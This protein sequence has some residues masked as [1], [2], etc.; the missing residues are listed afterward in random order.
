MSDSFVENSRDQ[1]HVLER[2]IKGLPGIRGYADKEMRRNADYRVRQLI[3]DELDKNRNA[4]LECQNQLLRNGGLAHMDALNRAV[5]KVQNLADRVRTASYGYAGFFDE[6][7]IGKEELNA[8]YSFDMA[9]LKDV[10]GLETAVTALR[11]AIDGQSDVAARID[12]AV[13]AASDLTTLFDRRAR[14]IE[15]PELLMEPGYA[16]EAPVATDAPAL[17]TD[18]PALPTNANAPEMHS[19]RTVTP[20]DEA[21]AAGDQY[22]L[23]EPDK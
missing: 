8:L 20:S 21:P 3:A 17:P 12:Q 19:Y 23:I 15:A 6:V 10:A 7:R 13:A 22:R 9:L 14:A 4:L 11:S 5:N 2:L 18:A 16:P 1:Q